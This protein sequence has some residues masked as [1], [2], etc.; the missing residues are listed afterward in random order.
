MP[1]CPSYC[2][3]PMSTGCGRTLPIES[4]SSGSPSLPGTIR[5]RRTRSHGGR[6]CICSTDDRVFNWR[7]RC[8]GSPTVA[9]VAISSLFEWDIPWTHVACRVV[10]LSCAGIA[11]LRRERA[12]R[13][14]TPTLHKTVWISV[15]SADAPYLI[16][17]T[18]RMIGAP[19]DGMFS[20]K[21]YRGLTLLAAIQPDEEHRSPIHVARALS[22]LYP[23]DTMA[24]PRPPTRNMSTHCL[25][26]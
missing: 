13:E 16:A 19:C 6:H 22:A 26:E 11:M 15:G 25:R 20:G 3:R 12:L 14:R 2:P 8:F 21:A 4:T 10:A 9:Q 5:A 1:V 24:A 18:W 7:S 17:D 23:P